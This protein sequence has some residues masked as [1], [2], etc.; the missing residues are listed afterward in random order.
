MTKM[1]NFNKWFR[2]IAYL[3]GIS[4]I[5]TTPA[6]LYEYGDLIWGESN[7]QLSPEVLPEKESE[8]PEKPIDS[9]DADAW[10][11]ILKTSDLE[12]EIPTQPSKRYNPKRPKNYRSKPA[13]K[14]AHRIACE[15]MDEVKQDKTG[16]GACSGHGGVRYWIYQLPDKSLMRQATWRHEDHPEPLSEAERQQLDAYRPAQRSNPQAYDPPNL[17][18]MEDAADAATPVQPPAIAKTRTEK[19]QAEAQKWGFYDLMIML[20]MC[21]TIAFITHTMFA[22]R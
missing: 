9:L 21:I 11:E 20:M 13:P 16:R 2:I 7:P 8:L 17:E 15:C 1:N 18:N 10:D 14:G 6:I 12:K 22:R 19:E 5:S 3:L 4:T